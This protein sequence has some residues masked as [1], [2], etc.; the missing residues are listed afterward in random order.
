MAKRGL[1][2]GLDA[3]LAVESNDG[4]AREFWSIRCVRGVTNRGG[5]CEDKLEELAASILEHGCYNRYW[6]DR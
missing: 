4:Q 6:L 5:V 2:R 1:G 3:L